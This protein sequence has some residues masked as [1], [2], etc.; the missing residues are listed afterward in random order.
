MQNQNR[1]AAIRFLSLLLVV[2]SPEASAAQTLPP[3]EEYHIRAI[4]IGDGLLNSDVIRLERTARLAL[5]PIHHRGATA[6]SAG[7][8]DSASAAY[9]GPGG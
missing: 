6:C 5:I 4:D 9:A 3:L 1:V 2:L 8:S 7:R